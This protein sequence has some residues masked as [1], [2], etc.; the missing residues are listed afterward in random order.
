MNTVERRKNILE[1]ALRD[2]S[3]LVDRL[4]EDFGV[5]TVTIR[6]D[7]KFLDKKNL[8]V[9]TH[10]GAVINN[11]LSRELS[12]DEKSRK[13][14]TTKKKIALKVSSLIEEGDAIIVDSGTTTAEVALLLRKFKNLTVM[15]NGLNVAQNLMGYAGVEIHMTGGKLRQKTGSFYGAMAEQQLRLYRFS[16]VIL[17]VDGFNIN[18]GV[19]THFEQE[20]SLNRVM[21]ESADQVI[22][23]TDSSK[24]EHSGFYKIVD[25]EDIEVLVTDT[26]ISDKIAQKL[27]QSGIELIIA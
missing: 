19:T 1:C 16:K 12:L 23:A 7:L 13:Q 21:C 15:T 8:L 6:S 3:V 2:K 17:G 27:E 20:A 24:F 25:T 22:V 18:I 9:R 10:G 14:N 5:S 26:G 11:V 4:A